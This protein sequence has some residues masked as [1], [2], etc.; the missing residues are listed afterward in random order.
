MESI[1]DNPERLLAR[2]REQL[3]LSQVRIM[4]LEDL[5]DSLTQRVAEHRGIAEAVQ[6]VADRCIGPAPEPPSEPDP[7]HLAEKTAQLELAKAALARMERR[8]VDLEGECMAIKDS[9]SWRWT[10]PMRSIG[11]WWAHRYGK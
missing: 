2:I 8:L 6:R 5:R 4:E 11:R 3:L 9:R 10:A 1:E 7:V